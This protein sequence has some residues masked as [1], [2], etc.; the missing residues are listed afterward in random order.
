LRLFGCD[1]AQGYLISKPLPL[2]E[3]V[4]YLTFGNSQELVGGVI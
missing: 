4:D 3:L 2:A 1:Q